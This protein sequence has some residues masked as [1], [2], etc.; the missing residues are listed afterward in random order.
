MIVREV[1]SWDDGVQHAGDEGVPGEDPG[2]RRL[3][4]PLEAEV[5][6]VVLIHDLELVAVEG[7]G[8]L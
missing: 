6:E 2:A 3:A 4:G 7:L 8:V 1:E 5:R